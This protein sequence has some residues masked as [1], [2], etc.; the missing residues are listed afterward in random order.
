MSEA[1]LNIAIEAARKAG[2][3]IHRYLPK[4]GRIAVSK[5]TRN[6]YVTEVDRACE[7]AIVS[8]IRKLHPDHAILAEE[9][10]ADGESDELWIIDP[11][12]GTSNF[13]HGIPHYAI[14]IAHQVRGKL[15]A[16]VIYDPI[17]E[18]LFTAARGRGA[19]L[20]DQRIRVTPRT[21][22]N[23]AIMATA[24]PFRRR[25]HLQQSLDTLA[26]VFTEVEDIRRAGSA[27]LDLAY[28]AAGRLDGYWEI[29]L[30]RWDIA[31]GILLVREA[32]GVVTDFSGND[33]LERGGNIIAAPYKVM[34]A[35]QPI[36]AKHIP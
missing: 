35:L 36:I 30:D 23:G 31:A 33:K 22:L 15:V 4:M 25:R 8:H 10:G 3:I 1:A 12:D 32:G 17:K 6:D 28:V 24:L 2:D 21:G 13:L 9:G 14:S 26:D 16:A 7:Y 29:G 5:K 11:L 27:A 34:A 20:N 18:E 19:Y